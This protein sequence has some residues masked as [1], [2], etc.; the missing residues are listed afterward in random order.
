MGVETE[1]YEITTKGFENTDFVVCISRPTEQP[2]LARGL[3]KG[4]QL[5]EPQGI[6]KGIIKGIIRKN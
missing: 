3:F 1:N 4:L 5:L 6:I 2:S